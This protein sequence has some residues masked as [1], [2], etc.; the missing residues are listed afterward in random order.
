[1]RTFFTFVAVKII[2][3]QIRGA[4][5]G[6]LGAYNAQGYALLSRLLQEHPLRNGDEWLA[7]LMKEDEMLG[8]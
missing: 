6:D 5:R 3:A 1:M 2:L 4:G 7:K 8:E